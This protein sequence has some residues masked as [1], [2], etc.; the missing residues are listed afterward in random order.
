[1]NAHQNFPEGSGENWDEWEAPKHHDEIHVPKPV[2]YLTIAMLLFT[3][4]SITIGNRLDLGTTHE[5]AMV[6]KREVRFSF[7][8]PAIDAIVA[9]RSDGR[10][11]ELAA[12]REE[13][14]PRLV[15]RGIANIRARDG[16][17]A[18]APL[19]LAETADGQRLL[20]DRATHRTVRLAAFGGENQRSFDAVF[21]AAA[22]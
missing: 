14:F 11:F 2:I 6:A 1:M 17:P 20:I 3:L 13:I 19:I 5:G 4:V 9:T 21:G 12:D 7:T 16:V 18:D 8:S 10:R 22:S 15:L